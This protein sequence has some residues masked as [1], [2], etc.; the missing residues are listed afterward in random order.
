MVN[1][2][3]HEPKTIQKQYRH[4]NQRWHQSQRKTLYTHGAFKVPSALCLPPS[5]TAITLLFSG[6]IKHLS[7]RDSSVAI[8]C[9]LL[10]IASCLLMQSSFF[11]WDV[12]FFLE[13]DFW[14]SA[15]DPYR[16]SMAL[17]HSSS[18]SFGGSSSWSV[19]GLSL[20]ISP[21]CNGFF[22]LRTEASERVFLSQPKPQI[23]KGLNQWY[24]PSV[25]PFVFQL[26]ESCREGFG[27][28]CM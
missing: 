28:M 20:S 8:F 24:L 4:R 6:M 22:R 2:A 13:F 15:A 1:P 5:K 21:S 23:H 27:N 9:W 7:T 12:L 10:P 3:K 14:K 19:S 17:F 25:V 11:S 18:M 26:V 16:W